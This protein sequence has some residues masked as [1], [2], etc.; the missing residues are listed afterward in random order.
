MMLAFLALIGCR[1]KATTPEEAQALTSVSLEQ[2]PVPQLTRD[3]KLP[4]LTH[5]PATRTESTCGYQIN[6]RHLYALSNQRLS[7]MVDI[8]R[9]SPVVVLEDGK[10]LSGFATTRDFEENCAGAFNFGRNAV[11]F[12]PTDERH[13]D[14][15]A[16][17]YTLALSSDFPL[18]TPDGDAWWAY[19]G[20]RIDIAFPD[21]AGLAGQAIELV[22]TGSTPQGRVLTPPLLQLSED[23]ILLEE[24]ATGWMGRL[25][26]TVP[27]GAWTVSL[28]IPS[29]G[30][31]MVITSL[32][33]HHGE[34]VRS[35]LPTS[36]QRGGSVVTPEGPAS[37]LLSTVRFLT[38]PPALSVSG[39]FTEPGAFL[40]RM[41]VPALADISAPAVR[42]IIGVSYSPLRIFEDGKSLAQP[43]S[44]CQK[45]KLLGNGRYCHS[46]EVILLS[47]S[48]NTPP[49]SNN[50]TY[51][52]ALSDERRFEGGWWLYPGD[53][54]L[55]RTSRPPTGKTT[56]LV[57]TA[58]H[59]STDGSISLKLRSDG[60]VLIALTLTAE[61]LTEGQLTLPVKQEGDLGE[62]ELELSV[63]GHV[64]LQGASLEWD[65]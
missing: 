6:A 27:D 33:V 47:S 16:H 60:L 59:I 62:I 18:A 44:S 24:D 52:F 43:N 32:T 54:I 34:E 7:K 20:T 64:V 9:V 14:A 35:I 12:S 41:E 10:P 49:L 25:P 21:D 8:G 46:H 17:T 4:E 13:E 2:L 63:T 15:E 38:E 29:D 26:I 23:K 22:V 37:D 58:K 11:R 36:T 57:L 28:V 31:Y 56:R 53:E 61:A 1:D 65:G 45:V 30:P 42:D 3:G 39:A 55:A 48:D 40:G 50:R 5:D 19:P 51:T